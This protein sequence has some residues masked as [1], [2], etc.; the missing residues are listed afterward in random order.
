MLQFS[1]VLLSADEEL[2]EGGLI[3]AV[4]QAGSKEGAMQASE[5]S[6]QRQDFPSTS[7]DSSKYY[8]GIAFA[9]YMCT[10]AKPS[11]RVRPR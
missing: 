6:L 3:S 1:A 9:A 10:M 4:L 8:P 2:D 11:F 5:S 7:R